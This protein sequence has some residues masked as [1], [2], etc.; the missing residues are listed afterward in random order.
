MKNAFLIGTVAVAA[1]MAS[2]D[3]VYPD[4]IFGSGN[5]N[6]GFTIGTDSMNTVE[7]GLRA[8]VRYNDSNMPENTFNYDGV[9]SYT[10]KAGSPDG[11]PAPAW[12]QGDN[13]RWNFEW[14]VN[15]DV[16]GTSGNMLADFTY[17]IA[18]FKVNADGSTISDA[19]AFDMINGY[20]AATGDVQW[21]HAI[22]DNMTGNGNG[23]AISNGV[24]DA[25]LYAARIANNNVAQNSWN[26]GFFDGISGTA[27]EDWDFN[28]QGS[29]IIRL[30][31]FDLSGEV[32]STQI[33][34]N[35][36]PV[37]PAAFAGL[38]LLGVLGGARVIRRR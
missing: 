21:D 36:V 10:M 6:G 7:L 32:A 8:K 2:A 34:V 38:G 14:S 19:L 18:M 28:A 12:A 24:D 26:Y 3:N 33:T 9:D 23:V 29:Y 30:T 22:G 11:A 27:L 35:V 25:G 1:S 16:S 17:Q 13:A 20:N 5:L 15:T 4:V 37:P 31:A